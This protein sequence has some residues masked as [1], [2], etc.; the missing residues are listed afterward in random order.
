MSGTTESQSPT[1]K[2]ERRNKSRALRNFNSQKGVNSGYKYNEKFLST[3][4]Y[5]FSFQIGRGENAH[6]WMRYFMECFSS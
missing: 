6:L 2:N 3:E 4:F 5:F 1:E